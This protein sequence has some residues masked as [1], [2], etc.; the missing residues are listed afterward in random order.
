MFPAAHERSIK[1]STLHQTAEVCSWCVCTCVF[2]RVYCRTESPPAVCVCVC[3]CACVHLCDSVQE[4]RGFVL[5]CLRGAP[6]C[7]CVL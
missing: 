1:N 3:V 2:V 6:V 7:T 5:R 4:M